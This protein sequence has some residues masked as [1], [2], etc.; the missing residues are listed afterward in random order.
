[1]D[2]VKINETPFGA[3]ENHVADLAKMPG[4]FARS[5]LDFD[6]DDEGLLLSRGEFVATAFPA[7]HSVFVKSTGTTYAVSGGTLCRAD[8]PANWTPVASAGGTVVGLSG[9][10][11]YAEFNE[12]VYYSDG[13]ISGVIRADGLAYTWG[14]VNPATRDANANSYVTIVNAFG[15][16]SGAV[17]S[18]PTGATGERVYSMTTGVVADDTDWSDAFGTALP[19]LG[20]DK[21]AAICPTMGMIQ[22]P[23]ASMIGFWAGRAWGVIDNR[24]VFSRSLH[25]GLHDPAYDYAEFPAPITMMQSVDGGMF[26]STTEMIYFVQGFDPDK[27]VLQPVTEDAAFYGS[28]IAVPA[29]YLDSKRLEIPNITSLTA[30][31]LSKNGTCYGMDG[32]QI[33][34]PGTGI[35]RLPK[36]TNVWP[37]LLIRDGMVQV[38]YVCQ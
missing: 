25:Y 16:E 36:Y 20:G 10:V 3:G 6:I 4:G 24:V 11:W 7:A 34:S 18:G 19:R 9:R 33:R 27:W 17:R 14:V 5:I 21:M 28:G 22:F 13:T 1:M 12:S 32:G 35:H 8:P 29:E 38:V 30:A 31:W 15:E 23:P 37:S 2:A 26:V